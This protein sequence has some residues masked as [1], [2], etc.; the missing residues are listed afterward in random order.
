MFVGVY[1]KNRKGKWVRGA[2]KKIVHFT[3]LLNYKM[4]SDE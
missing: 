3:S 4:Y 2:R 1:L